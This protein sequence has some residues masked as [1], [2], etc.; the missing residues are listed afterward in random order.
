MLDEAYPFAA[1]KWLVD[2]EFRDIWRFFDVNRRA[3]KVDPEDVGKSDRQL[4]R[5]YRAIADRRVRLG[6]IISSIAGRISV[7]KGAASEIEDE[8]VDFVLGLADC[9]LAPVNK[10]LLFAT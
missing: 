9:M 2:R 10:R 5:E 4:K 7:T 6:L 3:G 1:P 8:V